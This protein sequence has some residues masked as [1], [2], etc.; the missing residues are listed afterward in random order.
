MSSPLLAGNNLTAATPELIKILT[1]KGPLS[2]N[3]DP[4]ALQV[5]NNKRQTHDVLLP[6]LPCSSQFLHENRCFA[7]KTGSGRT[8]CNEPNL[9][10]HNDGVSHCVT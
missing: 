9:Q 7:N 6:R 3:Q 4:L 1:A 10:K 2:V 8:Y 5:R